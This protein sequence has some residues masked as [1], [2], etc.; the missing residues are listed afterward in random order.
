[1]SAVRVLTSRRFLRQV[2]P[3]LPASMR[4]HY[5]LD[6]PAALLR[7]QGYLGGR[8]VSAASEF[9]VLDPATGQELTQVSDCGPAEAKQAVDAAYEAFQSWKQTTAKVG[10]CCLLCRTV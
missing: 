8:W 7:T 5:S 6:V 3:S 10:G 9:P 4:R 2:A 1:M